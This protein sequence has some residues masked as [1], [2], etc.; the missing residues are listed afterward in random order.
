MLLPSCLPIAALLAGAARL[1]LS[2]PLLLLSVQHGPQPGAPAV[3]RLRLLALF[4][5]RPLRR[6]LLRGWAALQAGRCRA[7]LCQLLTQPALLAQLLLQ[8]LGKQV[9][10]GPHLVN[11]LPHARLLLQELVKQAGARPPSGRLAQPKAAAVL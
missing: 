5:R 7:H 1:R 11:R 10:A 6:A 9:E 3:L 4:G 8:L 2:L